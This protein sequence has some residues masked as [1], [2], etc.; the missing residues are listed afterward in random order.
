VKQAEAI[1]VQAKSP[2][3]IAEHHRTKR[4]M[5]SDIRLLLRNRTAKIHERLH[6]HAGFAAAAA[7]T[8][9]RDDYRLLLSR[10]WGFHRAFE[11]V[12]GQ[13]NNERDVRVAFEDRGRSLM[14]ESDLVALGL[15]RAA[16]QRLPLCRALHP[17]R[18]EAEF[19]GALYVV[20][21]ST[22][23]GVQIAR[24]LAP[25]VAREGGGGR[26]FFLGYG[27]R[28]GAMWRAFLERLQD[29]AGSEEKEAAIVL[30]G[31]RTFS[32]FE[33]WMNGWLDRP[34][35]DAAAEGA[36]MIGATQ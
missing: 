5:I 35:V 13:F 8:I 15:H 20:E 7:G 21:G 4:A 30:G 3:R 17:P 36:L 11:C 25:L 27:D 12:F 18:S 22:L 23:G 14:L 6:G 2:I 10:L 16:I 9:S 19:I 28:H 33:I 31:M 24:A 26:S 34:T 29:C 1:E 32:D